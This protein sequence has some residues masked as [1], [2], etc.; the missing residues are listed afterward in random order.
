MNDS[1]DAEQC[2]DETMKKLIKSF[3]L[4]SFVASTVSCGL[5]PGKVVEVKN[6]DG[7]TSKVLYT[8]QYPYSDFVEQYPGSRVKSCARTIYHPQIQPTVILEFSPQ[9][10]GPPKDW[11]KD[12]LEKSGWKVDEA[13]LGGTTILR[14]TRN[15]D[16][17]GISI[18]G[19][20][21]GIIEIGAVKLDGSTG[22][23]VPSA[24][25]PIREEKTE[26]A[27]VNFDINVVADKVASAVQENGLYENEAL[28][29]IRRELL[30]G[31][32]LANNRN[33]IRNALQPK[34]DQLGGKYKTVTSGDFDLEIYND[35]DADAIF[36]S[37][38]R[39]EVKPKQ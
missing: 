27:V 14:A 6:S 5:A 1:A 13:N 22:A 35:S 10:V 20:I 39:L 38:R 30:V 16:M 4:L 21:V 23:V 31:N 12:K 9:K 26:A 33:E 32:R 8:E 36:I 15:D 25:K 18:F 7:T 2:V 34:F 37:G 11:Y 24:S 28:A 19:D 29:V 3:V 17:L